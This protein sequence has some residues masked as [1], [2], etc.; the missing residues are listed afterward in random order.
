MVSFLVIQL[1]HGGMLLTDVLI[2]P[3]GWF[4]LPICVL[5]CLAAFFWMSNHPDHG[6]HPGANEKIWNV[7]YYYW[8]EGVGL[9]VGLVSIIVLVACRDVSFFSETSTGE[10]TYNIM[11]V[12]IACVLQHV[13]LVVL[14]PKSSKKNLEEQ[15]HI[16][17]DKHTYIMTFLYTMCFGSFIGFSGAFP[18]LITDL[19]GYITTEGCYYNDGMGG[20]E[21][22]S[23]GTEF[24]CVGNNGEW[25]SETI[26]NPNA[27]DVFSFSWLGACVGSLIRPVGGMLADRHG[28]AKVTQI[29]IIWCCI[30]TVC[31]GTVVQKTAELRQP[32]QNFGLF[33]F[34]FLN[35]FFCVGAMNGTTFRTIGVLFDAKLAGPVLG[36]SSAIASYGA[37]VIPAMFGVALSA[38][39]P[40]I[41]LYFLAVYYAFCGVLNYWYYCRPLAERKG[42]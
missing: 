9:I 24:D 17:K 16:F 26:T 7:V 27:P 21:F 34:L 37:F 25:G 20:Q 8:F 41:T 5:S 18:K 36:W 14:S 40:E 29:L 12:M 1:L 28:G 10:V 39:Q 13:A 32:E 42:V 11:L 19:F 33:V 6:N 22:L 4:W 30:A 15:W 35:V 38:G 23:G 2:P 3:A 31:L